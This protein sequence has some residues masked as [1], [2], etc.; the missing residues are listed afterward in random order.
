MPKHTDPVTGD[1]VSFAEYATIKAQ[2]VIRRWTI[3]IVFTIGTIV[4]WAIDAPNVLL[5]WNL[6][7]SFFA[8]V[9]ELTVGM[10]QFSQTRRDAAILR[11]LHTIVTELKEFGKKDLEHAQDDLEIDKDS[12][13]VLYEIVEQIQDI[14]EELGIEQEFGEGQQ[15]G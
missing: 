2:G 14:K 8:V 6:S 3:F 11:E 4:C 13:K 9:V 12:N 10:A 7:A 15:W 5:W 1:K